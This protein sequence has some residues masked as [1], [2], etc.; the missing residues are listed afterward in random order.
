MITR[1]C[2]LRR[3][4]NYCK[5]VYTNGSNNASVV[6]NAFADSFCKIYNSVDCAPSNHTVTYD[7]VTNWDCYD[8]AHTHTVFDNVF[9]IEAIDR[10]LRKMKFGKAAGPDGL[11]TEHL[12]HAHPALIMHLSLLFKGMAR[13]KIVPD[14]FWCGCNYP[15]IKG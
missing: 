9:S 7:Q 5:Q 10:C 15:V 14:P 11:S 12:V 1:P 4:G 13:H 6:A 3:A 8:L 2:G